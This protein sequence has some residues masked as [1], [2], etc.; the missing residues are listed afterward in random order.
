MSTWLFAVVAA[1]KRP[2]ASM[3]LDERPSAPCRIGQRV[4]ATPQLARRNRWASEIRV[5]RV[6]CGVNLPLHE[7]LPRS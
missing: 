6:R 3:G 4:L 1:K 2:L 5:C 7:P